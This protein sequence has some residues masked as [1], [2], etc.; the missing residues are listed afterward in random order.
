MLEKI[1][2]GLKTGEVEEKI[3]EMFPDAYPGVM[4]KIGEQDP[5]LSYFLTDHNK[6]RM[7]AYQKFKEEQ[8]K[9]CL[10][11]PG[12]VVG[13]K[14]GQLIIEGPDGT[15]TAKKRKSLQK[16]RF[17]LIHD[18]EV[19]DL[20]DKKEYEKAKSLFLKTLKSAKG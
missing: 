16:G 2:R 5:V 13:E 12:K 18:G 15:Y 3:L 10:V 19:V 11:V 17:V 4:K 1:K 8:Y 6:V 7:K 14:E 20:L 9:K